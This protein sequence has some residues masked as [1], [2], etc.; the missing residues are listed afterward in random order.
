MSPSIS[1]SSSPE[2]IWIAAF[3]TL[4]QRIRP[5]FIRQEPHQQALRYMQG[6]MSPIERK[7]GWQVAEEVGQATPYTHGMRNEK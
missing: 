5:S 4:S 7:N 6:L 3:N 1:S 2:E